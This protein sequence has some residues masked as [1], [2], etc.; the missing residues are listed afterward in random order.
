MTNKP[1]KIL[2]LP[3]DITYD[4][5]RA[6]FVKYAEHH[7]GKHWL[8]TNLVIALMNGW[9]GTSTYNNKSYQRALLKLQQKLGWDTHQRPTS[10][11]RGAV[12]KQL[13]KLVEEKLVEKEAGHTDGNNSW[14]YRWITDA[15]KAE[16]ALRRDV[17]AQAK[18]TARRLS[19]ALGGD[20]E[21]GV[22]PFITPDNGGG[23]RVNLY[24]TTAERLLEAIKASGLGP[25][26]FTGKHWEILTSRGEVQGCTADRDDAR[27]QGTAFR[28][29][30]IE[31]CS[32]C[33]GENT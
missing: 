5:V 12:Q 11:Q 15:M 13:N 31:N 24:G 10:A 2:P 1:Q 22:T 25:D 3:R 17:G 9:D 32:S 30:K 29:V 23:I 6:L 8:S 28:E 18:D 26:F 16:R 20:G 4:V 19:L 27:E 14:G 33:H 21:S 7:N